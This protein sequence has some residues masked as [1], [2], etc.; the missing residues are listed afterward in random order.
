[1]RSSQAPPLVVAKAT[2]FTALQVNQSNVAAP[3]FTD[4]DPVGSQRVKEVGRPQGDYFVLVFFTKDYASVGLKPG[5]FREDQVI[6]EKLATKV[7]ITNTDH[8][9][10]MGK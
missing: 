10:G 8:V 3:A 1:M 4:E 2:Y 5:R 7:L 9:G 6:A